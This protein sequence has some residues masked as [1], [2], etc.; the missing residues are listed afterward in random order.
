MSGTL[1]R[2]RM[3][4]SFLVL[5]THSVLAQNIGEEFEDQEWKEQ[6]TKLPP[7]PKSENLAEIMVGGGGAFS[8]FVDLASIDIGN[9]GVVRYSIL[10]R[11]V[12]GA[13]NVS[14]E[15]IRCRTRE[16]K[17]Y[18]IGRGDRSWAQARNPAWSRISSAQRNPYHA[19]LADRYFCPE[20]SPVYDS[21][22]AI[23]NIRAGSGV[24]PAR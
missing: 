17:I 14:F 20:R 9:D 10:A 19:D 6:V 11:S 1:V 13:E 12:G 23:R 4:A 2:W 16:R 8:F 7:S 15:G 5:L 18:A 21:A 3:L 22:A 24:A